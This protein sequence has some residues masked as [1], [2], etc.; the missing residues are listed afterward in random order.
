VLTRSGLPRGIEAQEIYEVEGEQSSALLRGVDEL[1]LVGDA[2]VGS[3]GFL[4]ALH[5]VAAAAQLT[6]QTYID[7]LICI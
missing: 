5:L 6:G 1:R 3:T 7:H 4:A 2:L